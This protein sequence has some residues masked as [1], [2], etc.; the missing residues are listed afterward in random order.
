MS[1]ESSWID[2]AVRSIGMFA[3]DGTLSRSEVE[4]LMRRALSDG[5]VDDDERRVLGRIFDRVKPHQVT[6][7]VAELIARARRDHGI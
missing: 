4:E 5:S 3:D 1:D 2:L 7:E 6:P